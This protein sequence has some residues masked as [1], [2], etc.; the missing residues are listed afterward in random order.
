MGN[1]FSKQV[2]TEDPQGLKPDLV[3][4]NEA[5]K[6]AV[7]VYLTI[8]FD[9][10]ETM[11]LARTTKEEKYSHL[12]PI[13]RNQG[14]TDVS[15][16]AFVVGS[17]GYWSLG[18]EE[19]LKYCGIHRNYA[20]LFRINSVAPTLSQEAILSGRLAAPGPDFCLFVCLFFNVFTLFFLY[21]TSSFQNARQLLNSRLWLRGQPAMARFHYLWPPALA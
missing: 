15:V 17:L 4:L 3:I 1:K 13:L 11:E 12:K 19:V 6:W 9:L 2:V 10:P 14:Y 8:P 16:D 5:T 7:V 21:F 18:N 20:M